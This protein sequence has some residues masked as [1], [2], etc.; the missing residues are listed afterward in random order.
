MAT[1]IVSN[2]GEDLKQNHIS[3][4]ICTFKR[5]AMLAKALGSILSQIT[6]NKFTFEVVIVDN[7]CDRSAEDTVH[8]LSLKTRIRIIYDC[9]PEQ[10]I[11]LARNRSI[12]NAEGNLIVFIDDDE[13]P[14]QNWLLA[15]Y[16]TYKK[17][18]A[19]GVLG[20][21]IPYYEGTPPDWLVKS[22]L[23]V[24]SSFQTGTVLSNSNYMRTGNVLFRK[25]ILPD[26]ELAFN[27]K[28]GRSGGEDANLF[29]RLL[30]RGYSFVWCDEARVFEHVPIERQKKSYLIKRAFIR[31]VTEAERQDFISIGTL[32]SVVAVISYT[33]ILPF[34]L[35]A[36]RHIFMKYL[37]KDCDHLAKLLAHFGIKL[38]RERN[39]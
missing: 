33:V 2:I 27:P 16:D 22:D 4:C 25:G 9:E 31:G 15:L 39:F 38:M 29:D 18:A 19:D 13:F 23:C 12:R 35:A 20:P 1:E 37:I 21:V 30:K 3:V 11:S 32:K 8:R 10:N 14:E 28:L 5:P 36:G 26:G 34:M 24:R 17:F 6:D 7:D